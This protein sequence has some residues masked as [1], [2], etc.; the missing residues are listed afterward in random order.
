MEYTELTL[1][2]SFSLLLIAI[3]YKVY[4]LKFSSEC[5]RPNFTFHAS[6][7]MSDVE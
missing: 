6:N 1:E 3:A 4:K 5:L 2:A 7:S